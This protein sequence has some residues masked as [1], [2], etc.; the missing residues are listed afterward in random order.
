MSKNEHSTE[1]RI[2]AS[3]GK[4]L[5]C[6]FAKHSSFEDLIRVLNSHLKKGSG[7]GEWYIPV[8]DPIDGTSRNL[9]NQTGYD[10]WIKYGQIQRLDAYRV[11][12][13]EP[14]EVSARI[15]GN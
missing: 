9:S 5:S 1:V 6:C 15:E 10:T 13:T 8:P 3:T 7:A 12:D 4:N 14:I 11:Q 2:K